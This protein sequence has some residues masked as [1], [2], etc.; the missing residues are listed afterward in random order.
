MAR[1]KVRNRAHVLRAGVS[2]ITHQQELEMRKRA[3]KC[4]LCGIWMTS[5]PH[6][7]NSKELDH[8]LPV[9]Q[10]GTHTHGNVRIVCRHCNQSRPKDGTDYGGQL[11]LWAFGPSPV[12]RADG[13]RGETRGTCRKG[14]HPWVPDNVR[15]LSGGQRVCVACE[16]AAWRRKRGTDQRQRQ[17]GCGALFSPGNR[18]FMCADCRDAAG[19]LAAELHATG[20]RWRDV[21]PLLGYD[22]HNGEG[23][24]HAAKRIG[25]RPPTREKKAQP[26]ALC[27]CGEALNGRPV[28]CAD[29]TRT[30]ALHALKLHQLGKTH[31]QIAMELGYTSI[32]SVTNLLKTVTAYEPRIGRPSQSSHTATA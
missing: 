29:C 27:A 7:P 32:T 9:N 21:A 24:R 31:W 16:R 12:S 15:T 28:R 25:Y 1:A 19:R 26:P 20:M 18:T 6:L 3:R 13:R 10:G 22:S 23:A 5:K 11:T 17:C 30:R 8:I 14:L 4:P 2:D